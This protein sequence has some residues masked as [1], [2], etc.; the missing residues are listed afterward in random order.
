VTA[1]LSGLHSYRR[2][3]GWLGGVHCHFSRVGSTNDVALRT[4][5]EGAEEGLLVTADV[6]LQ[7]RGRLQR[8]WTAPAGACLLMS[9]LFRPPEPF[10]LLAARTTMV[11]GL[12]LLHSVTALTGLPLQLK[13]P[14]DLISQAGGDSAAWV[15]LAGMLSEVVLTPENA[16]HGLV[17]GIGLNVNVPDSRLPGLAPNATSLLALTGREYNL[18]AVL[19]R[20]LAAIEPMYDRLGTGWDPTDTWQRHLAWLGEEVT[21]TAPTGTL[22]GTFCGVDATGALQLRRTDGSVSSFGA[23]DI[24]LRSAALG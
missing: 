19:D 3:D 14:N 4:A 17:V 15:K 11:C 13:W 18:I 21:V 1:D 10:E 24:S 5:L 8:T 2:D 23:G 22:A 16:P 6:Q 7:G 9:M 20:V 12:G